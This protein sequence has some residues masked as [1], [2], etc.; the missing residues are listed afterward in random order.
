MSNTSSTASDAGTLTGLTER[1]A[2]E[3]NSLFLKSFAGFTLVAVIAHILVWIW[4][5]WLQTPE[6]AASLDIAHPLLSMFT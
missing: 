6:V 2:N 5:P 1:E 3:F 4:R